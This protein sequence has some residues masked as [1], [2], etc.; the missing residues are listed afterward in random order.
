M[1]D[2]W[3]RIKIRKRYISDL[4]KELREL[5]MY[6]R[7]ENHISKAESILH[8]W[9][10]IGIRDLDRL[11]KEEPDLYAKIKKVEELV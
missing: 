4:V 2:F 7:D 6:N 10:S 3:G 8:Y 5:I 1:C 9:T 11:S